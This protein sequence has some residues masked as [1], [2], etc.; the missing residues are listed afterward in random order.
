MMFRKKPVIIDAYQTDVQVSIK[1]LEGD[2]IADP[3]DWI[4]TGVKG[5]RYPCKDDIFWLTYDAVDED[6][7]EICGVYG[8]GRPA[9]TRIDLQAYPGY[10]LA[11]C[12][13]HAG[14][15]ERN[16][17]LEKKGSADEDHDTCL[18]PNHDLEH[19]FVLLVQTFI[20]ES[21]MSQDQADRLEYHFFRLEAAERR[22]AKES[23]DDSRHRY[24]E[25]DYT[26]DVYKALGLLVNYRKIHYKSRT[27]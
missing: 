3:G 21:Y 27:A 1:T 11:V 16:D 24:C 22:L 6:K 19:L 10:T 7:L 13:L 23:K 8:C 5:E 12:Y 20:E 26:A 17:A 25:L 15:D 2:M 9:L 14:A 4:I 18:D